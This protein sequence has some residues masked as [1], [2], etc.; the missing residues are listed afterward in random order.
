M[1]RWVRDLDWG[2]RPIS[3]WAPSPDAFATSRDSFP[4][5][6]LPLEIKHMIIKALLNDLMSRAHT[7]NMQTI[8]AHVRPLTQVAYTFGQHD[9]LPVLRKALEHLHVLSEEA[10][11]RNQ[12]LNLEE[13][14]PFLQDDD[15]DEIESD[16]HDIA[17]KLQ[18]AAEVFEEMECLIE[19]RTVSDELSYA[20]NT[21]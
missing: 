20:R 3:Y 7:V 21:Y 12:C 6:R 11:M 13:L 5:D 10:A 16:S 19:T 4:W 18:Y 17:E 8:E 2:R 1:S 15:L 14:E 9:C